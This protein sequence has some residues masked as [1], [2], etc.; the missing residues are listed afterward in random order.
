VLEGLVE[1]AR[2]ADGENVIHVLAT[3]PPNQVTFPHIDRELHFERDFNATP[4]YL[5]ITL[6]RMTVANR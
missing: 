5:A 3:R 4:G 2:V 1:W 6:Q